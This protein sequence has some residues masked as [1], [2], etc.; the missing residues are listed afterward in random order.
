IVSSIAKI[1]DQI[2]ST[3]FI[4]QSSTLLDMEERVLLA[5]LNQI[6]L[7][8]ARKP[9]PPQKTETE[10]TGATEEGKAESLKG[11]EWD[12]E[13]LMER[14]IVRILL[15]YGEEKVPWD[16][17]EMPIAAWLLLNMSEIQFVDPPCQKIIAHYR[18]SIEKQE[19][20]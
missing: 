3:L 15:N 17:D 9:S 18:Q 5:E 13:K 8:Q 12:S 11:K 19:V 2:K 1:P 10:E 6:K 20:P 4:R 14:E 7:K 16:E